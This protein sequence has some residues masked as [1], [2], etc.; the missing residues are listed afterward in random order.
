MWRKDKLKTIVKS[1]KCK[2]EERKSIL[3][4]YKI[5]EDHWL[6]MFHY[7]KFF[8]QK[9]EEYATYHHFSLRLSMIYTR[10]LRYEKATEAL[11]NQELDVLK[12]RLWRWAVTRT[13]L[14]YNVGKTLASDLMIK[15][16]LKWLRCKELSNFKMS[17]EWFREYVTA[18]KKK[19]QPNSNQEIMFEWMEDQMMEHG[20]VV[21]ADVRE[22][23]KFLLEGNKFKNH[24]HFQKFCSRVRKYFGWKASGRKGVW[25]SG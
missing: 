3:K 17:I 5:P 8:S 11:K 19:R 7:R 1:F 14:R 22:K 10:S 4:H 25:F 16:E 24:K 6:I 12:K 23:S 15:N 21:V 9:V 20:K 18:P 2:E 13:V